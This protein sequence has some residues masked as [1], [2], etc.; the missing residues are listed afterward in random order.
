MTFT[1]FGI[2]IGFFEL[3]YYGMI[4][5]LGAVAGAV[6]VG[7]LAKKRG[8]RF[9]QVWDGLIWV[10]V[11]GIIGARIWHVLTP[12]PS[13]VSSGVT[14][15][16]YLTHPLDL[17]NIR[18]GGL[19]IYGAI[20]GGVVGLGIFCKRK[21]LPFVEWLDIAVPGL[22]LGQAIGRWANYVNGELCGSPTELPWGISRCFNTGYPAGTRFHPVFLY[23]SLWNIM[24]MGI[25][26]LLEYRFHDRL[27]NGDLLLIYAFLYSLG[28][29]LLE[30]I[31]LDSSEVFKINANWA[32]ALVFMVITGT[33]FIIRHLKKN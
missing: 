21:Q 2:K 28:R 19:G 13:L 25:L 8:Y 29:F 15:Y 26:L 16:Y 4:L 30:Y 20:L 31:R 10:L 23:E 6:L 11:F 14:T 18:A 22:A 17:I 24:N 5:M 27:K 12:S 9:D 7:Q 3:R 33:I 32:L 1:P